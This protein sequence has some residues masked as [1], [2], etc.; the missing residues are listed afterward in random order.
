VGQVD[1][2]A[3]VLFLPAE[4]TKTARYRLVPVT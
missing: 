2:V 3:G 1:L 4:N